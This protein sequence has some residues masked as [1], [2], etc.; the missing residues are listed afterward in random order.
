ML[1]KSIELEY[2][3]ENNNINNSLDIYNEFQNPLDF[4]NISAI[5]KS[6]FAQHYHFLCKQCN[7]V[8]TIKFIKDCKI[9]Y[10]CECKDSS[11]DLNIKE[12]YN[13]LY[14]FDELDF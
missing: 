4:S 9:R 1:E 2:L 3:Y 12:I 5:S 11:K 6:K 8:S 14:Y 7:R 10:I 13:Y